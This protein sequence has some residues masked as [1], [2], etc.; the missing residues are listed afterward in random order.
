MITIKKYSYVIESGNMVRSGLKGSSEKTFWMTNL[1]SFEAIVSYQHPIPETR[2]TAIKMPF[3]QAQQSHVLNSGS[4]FPLLML[5]DCP[6]RVFTHRTKLSESGWD[7][8]MTMVTSKNAPKLWPPCSPY[9]PQA[10]GLATC[11]ATALLMLLLRSVHVALQMGTSGLLRPRTRI[12]L[13][14]R[15]LSKNLRSM[16]S[17]L[18]RPN[19]LKLRAGLIMTSL[20]LSTSGSSSSLAILITIHLGLALG[21]KWGPKEAHNEK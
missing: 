11:F 14:R 16:P 3:L 5:S 17:C 18:S 13:T 20:T 6:M 7:S 4:V 15:R 21:H 8:K 19:A 2:I 12:A 9:D 10:L 1:P